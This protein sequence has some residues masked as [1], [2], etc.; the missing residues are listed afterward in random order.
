MV[1][2]WFFFF[3]I[4]VLQRDLLWNSWAY[5][6]IFDSILGKHLL[7]FLLGFVKQSLMHIWYLHHQKQP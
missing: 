6:K 1:C 4:V 5:S 2:F 3:V 7:G